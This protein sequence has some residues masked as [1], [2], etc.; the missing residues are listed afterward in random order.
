[1]GIILNNP[2][3]ITMVDATRKGKNIPIYHSAGVLIIY[4]TKYPAYLDYSPYEGVIVLK[5][6]EFE[7]GV[8]TI[9]NRD[10]KVDIVASEIPLLLTSSSSKDQN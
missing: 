6:A 7:S 5:K 3:H 8:F 4:K 9:D 10:S 1:M 2:T